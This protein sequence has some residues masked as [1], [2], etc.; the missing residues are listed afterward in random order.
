M[1]ER[2]R[3]EAV[4]CYYDD[5]N[6]CKDFTNKLPTICQHK[7]LALIQIAKMGLSSLKQKTTILPQ[8]V[9][10]THALELDG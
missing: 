2:Q 5:P 8:T 10:V 7:Y 1:A 3:K 4:E 6:Y 9:D